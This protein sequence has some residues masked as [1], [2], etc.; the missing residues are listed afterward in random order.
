M[1]IKLEARLCSDMLKIFEKNP[2]EKYLGFA[3]IDKKF[4]ERDLENTALLIYSR[5]SRDIKKVP[6]VE[7][8]VVYR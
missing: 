1:T 3:Y 2:E 5:V 7:V 4:T 6:R 8:K